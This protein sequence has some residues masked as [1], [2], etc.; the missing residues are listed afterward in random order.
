MTLAS[1][2]LYVYSVAVPE[3]A[4][5]VHFIR[6]GQGQIY[7][8]TNILTIGG[9]NYYTLTGESAGKYVGTWSSKPVT[10]H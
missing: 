7:N 2:S 4:T 6:Y 9:N 3:G 10:V 8:Q 5:K 1:A